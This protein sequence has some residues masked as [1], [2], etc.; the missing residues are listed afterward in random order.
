[1]KWRLL[2]WLKGRGQGREEAVGRPCRAM[3]ARRRPVP[4]LERLQSLLLMWSMLVLR[5]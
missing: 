5:Q 4:A 1:M 3:P 2:A